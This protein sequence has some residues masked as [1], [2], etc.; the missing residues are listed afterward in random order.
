M[1]MCTLAL[2]RCIVSAEAKKRASDPLELQAVVSCSPG[3][4]LKVK[5][6]SSARAAGTLNY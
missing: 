4:S 3:G 1:D 6:G 5:L 2:V